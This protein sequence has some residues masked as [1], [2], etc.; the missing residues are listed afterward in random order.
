MLRLRHP[1]IIVDEAHNSRTQLAFDT[2]AKCPAKFIITQKALAEGWDCAFAYILVSM[3]ELR[4]ATAV[5]QLLG[6]ILRQPQAKRRES[7][8][9]NRSYAYVVSKDFGETA[10][11]LRDSLVETAGFNREEAA[12]FV[13]AKQ[14][15][16]APLD[17]KRGENRIR[18]TP[19]DTKLSEEL[20]MSKVSTETR[21]KLKWSKAN[22]TLTFTAPL[23]EAETAEVKAVAVMDASKEAIDRAGV[24]SRPDRWP[25]STAFPADH[26]A[27][28]PL[29]VP[30]VWSQSPLQNAWAITKPK[31]N[32]PIMNMI[33]LAIV[34]TV[35]ALFA[36]SCCPSAPAPAPM[37]QAP[38]K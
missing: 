26:F 38:A 4:S 30:L 20:D 31:Y 10:A 32:T 29:A 21:K 19:V 12:E 37:Y 2:L 24:A 9:L 17:F 22:R 34:A 6:R 33:K 14:E 5:E 1:F 27:L 23:S 8:P 3:A 7:E 13:A 11:R 16:Q 35:A 36:A 25:G 18:I 28:Q 15:S